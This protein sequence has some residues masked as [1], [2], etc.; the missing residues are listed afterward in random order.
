VRYTFVVLAIALAVSGCKKTPPT[1]PDPPPSPVADLV[2]TPPPSDVVISEVKTPT[3]V[4]NYGPPATT[5]GVAPITVTCTPASGSEFPIGTTTVNCS[6]MDAASP[7]RTATTS[8]KVTLVAYVPPIP[9]LLVTKF[10][11]FGDSITAEVIGEKNDGSNPCGEGRDPGPA[12][13]LPVFPLHPKYDNS[14]E[15]YP[16]VVKRLLEQRYSRQTF[17]MA[18][19]GKRSE[20]AREGYTRFPDTVDKHQP[21]VVLLLQGI[22]DVRDKYDDPTVPI[23][24]LESDIRAAHARNAQVLISTLLPFSNAFPHGCDALNSTVR[25]TNDLIRSLALREGA[26]LVDPYPA[27]AAN[28]NTY[29]GADGL[30]P[31]KEGQEAIA[32]AFFDVIKK[33]FEA[34]PVLRAASAPALRPQVQVRPPAQRQPVRV[35]KRQQ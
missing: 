8:F 13:T 27:F 10:M 24:A 9:D 12:R 5:G 32:A 7:P 3:Q 17:T 2:F 23:E 21:Q 25:A 11:A 29:Q 4:V 31:T 34:V 30:H 1:N 18:N 35:P 20:S 14:E 28:L 15:T 19:E 16:A 6:G 26:L 22:I 33:N